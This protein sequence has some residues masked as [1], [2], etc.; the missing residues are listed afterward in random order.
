MLIRNSSENF[1]RRQTM[2]KICYA[3]IMLLIALT[4]L[5]ATILLSGER[6][7][8]KDKKQLFKPSEVTTRGDYVIFDVNNISTFVR[9]NG[10]FNRDPG[11][12]NS[13]FEWP[14]GSGNTAIYASGIWIGGLV[15][16]TP[17]VAVAEYSYE[18][19]AGPIGVNINPKDSRWKVYKLSRQT[20]SPAFEDYANWPIDNGAPYE[21]D[22]DSNKVPKL[23][24]DMTLFAVFNDN[25]PVLHTNMTTLPL[26][27]EV[28]L[29]VFA[30]NRSDA[31]GNTIYYKWK[32][33][34]KGG[35][36]IKDAYVTIWADPDLGD[37]GDDYDGCDTTL[38]LGFTYNAN[39]SDGVYGSSPPA[40]GF[41][42]LQGPLVPSSPTDFARFPDGRIVT[43]YKFQKMTSYLKYNNDN[44]DLGNPSNGQ[45]VYNYMKGLTRTGLPIYDNRGIATP[46]MFPGDPNL[47]TSATNWIES[48]GGGDRRFMMSAGPF[49][50]A[51]GDTQEIVAGNLI[52]QG[53]SNTNSV[54][55]LKN[56]DKL[57][58][59][60]YDINFGLAPPPPPP[61]V[62]AVGLENKVILSWGEFDSLATYIENF[63][64]FDTLAAAGGATDAYYN[65]EG[66]VVYQVANLSG[67]DPRVVAV[68]DI[69][70]NVKKVQDLVDD[71][72]YGP[73][74]R[75]VKDGGDYGVRRKIQLLKDQY[76][77]QSFVNDKDYY[78]VVT[79]YSYNLESVPKTLESSFKIKTV[80]PTKLPGTRLTSAYGDSTN[81]AVVTHATGISEATIIPRIVDP[82]KITGDVYRINIDTVNGIKT[83]WS[84]YNQTKNTW[85][86]SS[87]N[88]GPGQGGNNYAW[89]E[90]DGI[91]WNVFDVQ[92]QPNPDSST[93]SLDA[94]SSW[95]EGYRWSGGPAVIDPT[96]IGYGAITTGSDLPTY[97]GHVGTAFDMGNNVPIEI[98]FGPSETQKAYRM[99]RVGGVGTA[100]VIQETNPFVDVPFTVWDMSNPASPRQLTVSWRDQ[101]NDALFNPSVGNDE[102]EIA[103]IYHKTYNPDGNQWLYQNA[104]GHVAADWSDA[105]TASPDADI[106]YGMSIALVTGHTFGEVSS[107]I[108]VIPYKV[109]KAE[110]VYTVTTTKPSYSVENAKSD[111]NNIMAVPNPYFGANAYEQNQ[112][113]RMVRFTNLPKVATIRIF[114]LASDLVRVIDKDDDLTTIDWDLRNKNNL[115]VASGM[116]IIHIEMPGIGEKI[117]KV[118]VILAEE[119]LD[120]F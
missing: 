85:L 92:S 31:L 43:G 67:A 44:T 120:N 111:I 82:S 57:V 17:R 29:T 11:T 118:A 80:R 99:R 8:N 96:E 114:N 55:A 39:Q 91:Q 108:T 88:F 2:K 60:A 97:L 19:D 89:P 90:K 18:F 42:F 71:P 87:T 84:L 103:F 105:A 63:E 70:N 12:G 46:F 25:N 30:F 65:F 77:G 106:M 98:R 24:G 61:E 116:Y 112:F 13:G 45:E 102:L 6:I 32:L 53:S 22:A 15:N 54:T 47:D 75:V 10:S 28:Q 35:R 68:Y 107:K 100:Y 50:M 14:K 83:K 52:A 79:S 26:G 110:D 59:T 66:Y 3:S 27:V 36:D 64:A 16:D 37:S 72:N 34:N 78:F 4:L 86:L 115:P 94:T 119:R 62:I 20:F 49:N 9:N 38:G 104:S 101:T 81:K 21:Y 109:L 33:I 51:P 95:L 76:T 73:I 113:G 7:N 69:I 5:S 93:F 74:T 23:I 58:Q 1:R 40:V 117:L 41:D 48:E 56:A